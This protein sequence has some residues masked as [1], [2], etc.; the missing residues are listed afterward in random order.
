[1]QWR[2]TTERWGVIAKAFHWA[3]ALAILV[4]MALGWWAVWL[5]YGSLKVDVFWV[6]KS[7]GI[8]ILGAMGLRLI[9]R[10]ANPAPALP[11]TLKPWERAAAHVTHYGLYGLLIAMPV[12]GWVINSAANFPLSVFGWFEVPPLVEPDDDIKELAAT[13]HLTLF[14]LIAGLLV[15]HVGAAL[16]HHLVLRDNV[17]RRMLPFGRLHPE[18]ER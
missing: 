6:H 18:I 5:P 2:N 12:S 15:L 8:L 9:W 17:L 14:W 3:L 11:D 10:M 16:K 4:M 7:L 13:V 1:M